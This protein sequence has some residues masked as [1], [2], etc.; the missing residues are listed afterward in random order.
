[1]RAGVDVGKR[2]VGHGEG[3]GQGR[4]G[5]AVDVLD[6]PGVYLGSAG[7]RATLS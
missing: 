1:V 5:A 7:C 6:C 3:A 4:C 2:K